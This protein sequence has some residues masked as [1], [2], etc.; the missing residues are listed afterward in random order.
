MV[1]VDILP[2]YTFE[3]LSDSLTG[4]WPKSHFLFS[5]LLLPQTTPFASSSEDHDTWWGWIHGGR[6]LESQNIWW[7]CMA[8]SWRHNMETS[9]T[10]ITVWCRYSVVNYPKSSQNT[11]RARY[12]VSS[13]VQS[14]IYILN[15]SPQWCVQYHVILDC[16]ITALDCLGL[17][18]R[19]PGNSVANGI[20]G[21]EGINQSL[22][23]PPLSYNGGLAK[24]G[25][26]S[27]VK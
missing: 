6:S 16:V 9:F 17:E 27:S 8:T 4:T 22:A 11:V 26:I 10:L 23:K 5:F 25:L 13:W 2:L 21:I 19:V 24:P 20:S 12:G 15:Q 3:R 1:W 7:A 14:L 18:R